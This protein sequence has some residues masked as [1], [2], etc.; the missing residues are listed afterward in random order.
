MEQIGK[1][2]MQPNGWRTIVLLVLYAAAVLVE[3]NHW[4]WIPPHSKDVLMALAVLTARQGA[5]TPPTPAGK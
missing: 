4:F 5:P 2:I 3:G 1:L